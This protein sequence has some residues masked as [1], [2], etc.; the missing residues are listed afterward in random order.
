MGNR[1]IIDAHLQTVGLVQQIL[2]PYNFMDFI[3][4]GFTL[5][6]VFHPYRHLKRTTIRNF[7]IGGIAIPFHRAVRYIQVCIRTAGQITGTA[8][9]SANL[10]DFVIQ[11]KLTTYGSLLLAEQTTGQLVGNHRLADATLQIGLRKRLPLEKRN[12]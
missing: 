6:T 12:A 7:R 5:L 10:I 3:T 4:Q 8:D 9:H 1:I 2:F 11:Q